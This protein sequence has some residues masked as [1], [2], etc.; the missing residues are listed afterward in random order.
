MRVN[1]GCRLTS[2]QYPVSRVSYTS[3]SLVASGRCPSVPPPEPPVDQHG[4]SERNQGRV[5]VCLQALRPAQA[6]GRYNRNA[7][8]EKF[9]EM[10]VRRCPLMASAAPPGALPLHRIMTG[11]ACR[12]VG[13][14]R[15]RHWSGR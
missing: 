3:A 7:G 9:R 6:P 13:V 14:A 5:Q 1:R 11:W 4:R 12:G 10:W 15:W 8:W 2:R